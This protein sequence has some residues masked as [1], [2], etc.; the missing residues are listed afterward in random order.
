[1]RAVRHLI[2]TGIATPLSV[3][4]LF[5]IFAIAGCASDGRELAEPDDWQTTTTRPPPPTSAPDTETS[6]SGIVLSSADFAPGS[7]VP[8]SARCSSGANVFPQLEWTP[9]PGETVELAVSLSDQTSPDE[10]ILLWL[11]AGIDP[12]LVTLESGLLPAGAFETLNDYGNPGYGTPCLESFADGRRDL[13]FRLYVL[14]R[15]SDIAPG[16]PGNEAW[17]TLRSAAAESATLLGRIDA[18]TS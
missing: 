6:P 18:S 13:Q 12:S 16:D 15:P 1:M 5:S 8:D 3:A 10:P 9:V 11:M 17:Q 7:D 14:N 4:L 2:S